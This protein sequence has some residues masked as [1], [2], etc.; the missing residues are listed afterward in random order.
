MPS[1]PLPRI[2]L[3]LLSPVSVGHD[4]LLTDEFVLATMI[5]VECALVAA[6]VAVGAAPREARRDIDHV[7]GIDEKGGASV[8]VLDVDALVRDS[9]AGGNPVIP[10]VGALKARVP[11]EH[12]G[13]IHR[14][15]T[16]QDILDT[17][18][19]VV[20]QRAVDQTRRSV[21]N[22]AV[23]ARQ[24]ATAHADEVAAARTLTQH[25]V[26]TTI[27]ARAA[28]WARGLERAVTRLE[29]LV[30]PAQL[31]GAGGTLASFV[32]I[33]GSTDA[34][35]ALPAAFARVLELDA[36]DAP[37]HVTRWPV[38]EIGDALVQA[39][40]ALGKVA[41]D[42]A[43]LSRTEIGEVS[44]GIGGGSSAMP[45]KQ[46]PAEAVLLRSAALRAPQLGATL[47]LASAL[48]VDERP[49]G[50]WHA[51]WPTLRELLR[52]AVGASAHG[53]SLLAHLRVDVEA[54]TVNAALT[55]GRLVSERLR[56]V[57]VPLIG[58]ERFADLL[59]GDDDLAP[60]LR[61]LPEAADLD[62]D[63]LLDPA[64]YV[65]LAARLA[66]GTRHPGGGT[67]HDEGA[68]A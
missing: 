66:R 38:T 24:L 16:S 33:A 4:A 11:A 39:I 41:A 2:D 63:A 51:E 46:N 6:Y 56:G 18:L 34:A 59:D 53:S 58:V 40:D 20:A 28:T 22:A 57:L 65:G 32:E 45:Q 3:G 54:A 35:D 23:W 37:W 29:G 12:R 64:A 68:D 17:A 49:D 1:E 36:P 26:P 60:R 10:L 43:T 30:F 44:E 27:G 13:W 62:V 5:R 9:V 55:G 14:G 61:A 50:A 48:A 8:R 52:L 47:H 42:V 15:A 21:A 25:A 7:F 19:M 67:A 31:A